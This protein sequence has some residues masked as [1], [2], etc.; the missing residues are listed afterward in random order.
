MTILHYIF[1][2]ARPVPLFAMGTEAKRFQTSGGTK[3]VV[4]KVV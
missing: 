2:I 3:Q 1:S 4:L